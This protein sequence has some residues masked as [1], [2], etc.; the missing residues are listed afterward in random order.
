MTMNL[1]NWKIGK[2]NYLMKKDVS[3]ISFAIRYYT[4]NSFV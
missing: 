1:K 4:N 2:I 3:D